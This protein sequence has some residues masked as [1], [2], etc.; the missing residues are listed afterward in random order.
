MSESRLN[1]WDFDDTLA[2]SS[3]AVRKLAAEHPDI[4][5]RDW[6]HDPETS[7]AAAE[8][9]KPIFATWARM[10]RTPGDHIILTGR[11]LAPVLLWLSQN[12]Q[13]PGIVEAIPKIS[14]VIS[15]SG[16]G[17]WPVQGTARRKALHVKDVC[18]QYD[19]IHVYDDHPTNLQTIQGVC[20]RARLHQIVDGHF[21]NK[22]GWAWRRGKRHRYPPT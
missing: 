3:D 19:E 11:V 5:P 6:W 15:T 20:P 16:D 1:I 14:D 22:S 18:E 10:A 2:W 4:P 7:S 12:G 9:T 8:I 21:V 13:R 17:N